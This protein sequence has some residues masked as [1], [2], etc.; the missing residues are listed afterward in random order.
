MA[1]GGVILVGVALVALVGHL[2]ASPVPRTVRRRPPPSPARAGVAVPA[3]P[4]A[5]APGQFSPG[6]CVSYPPT[7]GNRHQTVFLDAGHGGIDPGAV[8]TTTAGQAVHEANLTLPVELDTMRLLTAEGYTVVVSR[9]GAGAVARLTP[10]DVSNG[11]LTPQGVYDDVA[12]R[13]V[14][15]NLAKASVLVGIYFD[16]GPSPQSAGSLTGYDAARSFAAQN[17]TLAQLVQGDVLA[18]LNSHG[19]QIP[20]AGVVSDTSLGG[21]PLSASAHAYGHLLLLGPAQPGQFSTPSQ[22]PGAIIEPLFVTDPFE[23]TIAASTAG[24]QAIAVGMAQAVTQDLAPPPT[25]TPTLPPAPGAFAQSSIGSTHVATAWRVAPAGA[26]QGAITVAEF[27]PGVTRLVLHAGSLQPVAGQTWV[28]GPQVG[29]AERA[30]LIAAFNGGFKLA[31][32]RGGWVSEGRTVANP[33]SGAASVVI[34]ADGGFDIGSWGQEVPAPGRAVASVRQNLQLLIDG[35]RPQ[36][37]NASS[38]NQLEQWWGIAY[39]AAPL[40]SRSALGITASGALVWAAGTDVSI[41]ALTDALLS[42][43]AVRAM[44]LDINAPLVRGFLYPGVATVNSAAATVSGLLPL[45]AG[46]TQTAADLTPAGSGSGAVP[47]CTYVTTCSRDFFT[48]V[49]APA[50]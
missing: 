30:R 16:A 42:H 17:L 25:P 18:Q 20:D 37:Q 35:G 40:I 11:L 9:T 21:P 50:P 48:V 28:N 19:W 41:P 27:D 36:L 33:V 2:L 14:C 32:S 5:V 34:Y 26:G 1:A 44:E 38:E 47:H 31:D 13:D 49:A 43:G 23:A 24:Q 39:R 3:T 7:A 45:V 29:T 12:A 4:H 46:Q 8:G 10:A 15:A 6:A 22:M